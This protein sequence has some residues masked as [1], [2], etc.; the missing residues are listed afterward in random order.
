MRRS[1]K[2]ARFGSFESQMNHP[3]KVSTTT[4]FTKFFVASDTAFQQSP[5]LACAQ[6]DNPANS[7]SPNKPILVMTL[8]FFRIVEVIK[9][10]LIKA[11]RAIRGKDDNPLSGLPTIANSAKRIEKRLKPERHARRVLRSGGN[12]ADDKAYRAKVEHELQKMLSEC[13]TERQKEAAVNAR[14]LSIL[15]Q[16]IPSREVAR[17]RFTE[18]LHETDA[19]LDESLRQ[20]VERLAISQHLKT[21][22]K[23]DWLIF[24]EKHHLNRKA[25][26]PFWHIPKRGTLIQRW[27]PFL[28]RLLAI[29]AVVLMEV[30]ANAFFFKDYSSKGLLGGI[31]TAIAT[32]TPVIVGGLVTGAF[33]WKWCTHR[34][35]L[36]KLTLGFIGTL[37]SIGVVFYWIAVVAAARYKLAAGQVE[38]EFFKGVW[39][40]PLTWIRDIDSFGLVGLSVAMFI[41]AAFE[42]W[43]F[44][45]DTYPGYWRRQRP[46]NISEENHD[47]LLE[48][49]HEELSTIVSDGRDEID[50]LAT[51]SDLNAQRFAECSMYLEELLDLDKRDELAARAKY[52]NAVERFQ[53]YL[54][55]MRHAARRKVNEA[56]RHPNPQSADID[57]KSGG[58]R[59]FDPL[60]LVREEQGK[61]VVTS[62]DSKKRTE[63]I[64]IRVESIRKEADEARQKLH[65]LG[66]A[67]FLEI[68]NAVDIYNGADPKTKGFFEGNLSGLYNIWKKRHQDPNQNH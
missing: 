21:T 65:E 3:S 39:E 7:K 55:E 41:L 52:Y 68:E 16:I 57:D 23:I 17:S 36:F 37:A 9:Q 25:E 45:G 10:R 5:S 61:T 13:Y 18:I 24:R 48:Y 54:F 2:N 11:W 60:K 67:T 27:V 31:I 38:E 53:T 58:G 30:V 32:S 46:V 4:K 15:D 19:R 63:N 6:S 22:S 14:Q 34:N 47:E 44:F 43:K 50:E 33:F 64:T 8:K 66:E 29:V 1:Q 51:T 12:D 40:N 56:G 59:E 62:E 28:V 42:G 49:W 35:W 20:N 26:A